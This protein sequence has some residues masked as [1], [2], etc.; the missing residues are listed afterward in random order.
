MKGAIVTADI[1]IVGAGFTGAFAAAALADGQRRIVV[2]DARPAGRP[3]FGGELI[4]AAGV[5]ILASL[6]L[7]PI[8]GDDAG[9]RIQG[10]R[11]TAGATDTPVL[12]PYGG[13]PTARPGGLA[14]DHQEI[15]TR[16]HARLAQCRGVE[17]R[18][19]QRVVDVLRR[20][21][22]IAGVRTAA[23]EEIAARL[24]LVADGRH[25]RMRQAI[26]ISAGQRPLSLSAMLLAPGAT[27]PSPGYAHICLGAPGPILAYP[28]RQGLRFCIDVPMDVAPKREELAAFL[29]ADYVN[30]LAEPLR[31]YM[32][33][34]LASSPLVVAGNHAVTTDRCTVPGAALLGDAAGCSHPLTASGMTNGLNDVRILA[35][36]LRGEGDID[37]ALMRYAVRR[38][39]FVRIREILADELYHAFRSH[40]SNC[41]AIRTGIFRYWRTSARGRAATVA[42][43]SGDDARLTTFVG[44]YLRVVRQSIQGVVVGPVDG[45]LRGR[46]H[47]LGGLV[48]ESLDLLN[49]VGAGVYTGTLR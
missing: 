36:E 42:L 16:V 13:V 4:H 46:A 18:S 6:G 22:R 49:R 43:L 3:H 40:G 8:L 11:V 37:E 35:E 45:S 47:S 28:L 26:G 7:W 30:A 25:S 34:A 1:V 39:R 23:G 32:L 19:G 14:I 20:H 38:Y 24:T 17:V 29:R 21:G 9:E 31:S 10:F 12:L 48:K 33:D 41:P 27:L 5:D 2:L 15:L 44:E